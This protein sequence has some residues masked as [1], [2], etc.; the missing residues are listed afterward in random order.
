MAGGDK[1]RIAVLLSDES[2]PEDLRKASDDWRWWAQEQ[3]RAGTLHGV[4]VVI[5]PATLRWR[6]D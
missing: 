5:D 1:E 6:H 4:V 3:A 2:V